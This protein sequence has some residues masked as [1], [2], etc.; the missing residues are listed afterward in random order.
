MI[1]GY[2]QAQLTVQRHLVKEMDWFTDPD[3][4]HFDPASAVV[5][6]AGL[7][8]TAF[9]AGFVQEAQKKS[10]KAGVS[11]YQR[12][13][14]RVKN[15]FCSNRSIDT[16][17]LDELAV[18]ASKAVR[19]IDEKQMLIYLTTTE[20]KIKIYLESNLPSDRAFSLAKTVR[21][22]VEPQLLME[23]E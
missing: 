3:E 22:A 10:K 5:G 8:I 20:D 9:L 19:A 18:Q 23:S 17:D 7:L 6:F 13:E 1:Q 11:V 16:D 15:I 12:L 21:Q 4:R 2:D 14:E